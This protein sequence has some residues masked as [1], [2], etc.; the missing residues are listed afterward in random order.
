MLAKHS[1]KRPTE[2]CWLRPADGPNSETRCFRESVRSCRDD[3]PMEATAI[4]SVVS[5]ATALCPG[6]GPPVWSLERTVIDARPRAGLACGNPACR[7][8]FG[9]RMS[10]DLKLWRACTRR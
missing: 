4:Q 1:A 2:C 10:Y 8:A 6:D 3:L 7:L 5:Q 9:G